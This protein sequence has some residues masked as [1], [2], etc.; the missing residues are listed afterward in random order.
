MVRTTRRLANAGVVTQG[1]ISSGPDPNN[2]QASTYVFVVN[3]REITAQGLAPSD[4]AVGEP[5]RITYDPTDPTVST[6]RDVKEELAEQ[7]CF[8]LVADFL[9]S[10]ALL[11]S[12][13]VYTR[14]EESLRLWRRY[15][16]PDR[17][18]PFMMIVT[19]NDYE[20]GTAIEKGIDTC[21]ATGQRNGG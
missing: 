6:M 7:V 15:Y 10:A 16:S 14:P 18:L 12:L 2:H 20:E 19:W 5:V 9:A 3:G 1:R 4:L 21:G 11:L 8:A 17:P 13:Y